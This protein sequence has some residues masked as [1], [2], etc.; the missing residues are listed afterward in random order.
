M[1]LDE[2]IA[3]MRG[4]DWMLDA[5]C[6]ETDPE[7]FF[8]EKGGSTQT[9]KK[10]CAR[11]DVRE[12]CLEYALQRERDGHFVQGVWGGK[13]RIERQLMRGKRTKKRSTR[14]VDELRDEAVVS[15]RRQGLPREMVAEKT[16]VSVRTVERVMSRAGSERRLAA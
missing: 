13:S 16:G 6:A 11:C 12:D 14:R 5:L 7:A 4:Q 10:I 8:P 15:M 3:M 9:A 2:L 1:T